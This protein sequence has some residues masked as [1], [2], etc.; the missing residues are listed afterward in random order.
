MDE[1]FLDQTVDSDHEEQ[2]VN[3]NGSPIA[4]RLSSGDVGETSQVHSS[5]VASCIKNFVGQV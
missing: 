1:R 5:R 3:H 4:R 2:P